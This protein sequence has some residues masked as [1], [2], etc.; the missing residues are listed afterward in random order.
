MPPEW[1]VGLLLGA[2]VAGPVVR[3][4]IRAIGRSTPSM[5]RIAIN[6]LR[7]RLG[8]ET[9]RFYQIHGHGPWE[10]DDDPTDH[11]DQETYR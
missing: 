2:L 4:A 5:H 11:P 1:L 3:F 6:A 10:A 9:I 8:E 7:E